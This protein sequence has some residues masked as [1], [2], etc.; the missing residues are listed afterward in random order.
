MYGT[1]RLL[2]QTKSCQNSFSTK[3]TNGIVTDESGYV[4]STTRLLRVSTPP[5]HPPSLKLTPPKKLHMAICRNGYISLHR[6]NTTSRE[7]VWEGSFPVHTVFLTSFVV[8]VV[9]VNLVVA[10]VVNLVVAYMLI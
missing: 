8:V 6:G 3:F 9:V 7:G 4:Y 5:L 1:T 10:V 2:R